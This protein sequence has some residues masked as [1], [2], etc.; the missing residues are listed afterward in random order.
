M[1]DASLSRVARSMQAIELQIG[2]IRV[3]IEAS[4]PLGARLRRRY[5]D[6][7]RPRGPGEGTL[8]LRIEARLADGPA[9]FATLPSVRLEYGEDGRVSIRG[10]CRASLDLQAGHGRV[11]RGDGLAGVDTLVRLSLSLL[12]P[13]EGWVLFHG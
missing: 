5:G 10:D 3:G 8:R 6:F 1:S 9:E 13:A 4:P 7:A 11:T 2:G 12:A